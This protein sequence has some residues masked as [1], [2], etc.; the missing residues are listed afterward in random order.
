MSDQEID[1]VIAYLADMA[2]RRASTP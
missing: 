2:A 1:L